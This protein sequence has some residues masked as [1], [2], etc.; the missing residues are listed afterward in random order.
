MADDIGSLARVL[1]RL[2]RR[3]Y[4]A[5]KDLRG[6]SDPVGAYVLRVDHVQG[7][8]FAAP[9]RLR[10]D[11]PAG[12]ARLPERAT[13]DADACRATA[14]FL[15]RALHTALADGGHRTGSGK[16]GLLEIAAL[17]Q[18]VLER[19]AVAVSREGEVRLRLSAGLPAAG[20]RILGDAAREL[21]TAR[22]PQALDQVF[23]E[24]DLE[25][26]DAQLRCIED[27]VALRAQL[28]GRGLVAFLA[29]GSCLPRRSGVDARPL[30]SAV[31][32][33]IP[34]SLAVVLETPNSGPLRG[35][36]VP[37]GVTLI[38]GGGYHGKSTLLSVLA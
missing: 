17:G 26:L 9:S 4:P 34:D 22:L 15:H 32:L 2:D 11:V 28:A 24:L 19:S 14:D 30:P 3:P 38:V 29:E 6:R 13:R 33:E 1:E 8:P 12:V 37:Q 18:E 36:A 7:D 25:G 10:I 35:L 27:Q 31:L 5:Y 20:R 23:A 21:L 16:S